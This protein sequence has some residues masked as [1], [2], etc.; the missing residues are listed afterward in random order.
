MKLFDMV[1]GKG[2]LDMLSGGDASKEGMKYLGQIPG[3]MHEAYD[4]YINA[5]QRQ[6]PGLEE[7]YKGAMGDPSEMMSKIGSGYQQSPGFKFALEQALGGA[8]RSAA[9]GG[10]AGSPMSQ[11]ENMGIAT[12]MANQDYGNY[13]DRALGLQQ[14]GASGSQ[15]LYD[16]GFQASNSLADQIA[17]M[18]GQ[19]SGLAYGGAA[20]KNSGMGSLIGGGLGMMAGG[21]FGAMVG[22]NLGSNLGGM[23]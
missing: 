3:Q 18:L 14:R 8:N 12:G 22:S 7:Y 11:Q 16:R 20:S 15:G 9:A 21:P 5:G 4:P 17:Q 19:K 10:M 2:L 23:R 13:M 1:S 6:L